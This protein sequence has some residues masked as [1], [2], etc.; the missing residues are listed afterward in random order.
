MEKSKWYGNDIHDLTFWSPSVK[1]IYIYKFG[2]T[3]NEGQ[4]MGFWPSIITLRIWVDHHLSRNGWGWHL[5]VR[6]E[7]LRT[8]EWHLRM[9]NILLLNVSTRPEISA[10]ISV[11]TLSTPQQGKVGRIMKVTIQTLY[12]IN[13]ILLPYKGMK[14]YLKHFKFDIPVIYIEC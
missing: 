7:I 6:G 14:K 10:P 4:L 3:W 12:Y 5:F 2:W 1:Y 8:S 9:I 11:I 13:H